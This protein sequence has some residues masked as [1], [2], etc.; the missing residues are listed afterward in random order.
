MAHI[1]FVDETL[2][3]GM[4]S[5][6]GMRMQAGMALPIVPVLD[7]TGFSRIEFGGSS[8]FE[9]MV[10]YCREN[11]WDGLKAVKQAMPDT[12]MRS[13]MRSQRHGNI[14]DIPTGNP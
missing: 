10:R 4:Q 6:W 14:Q 11:P 9:V 2:R 7:Q 12:I 8:Y 1:K 13:G 5:L 3:D